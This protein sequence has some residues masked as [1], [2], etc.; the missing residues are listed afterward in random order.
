[1]SRHSSPVSDQRS[2]RPVRGLLAALLLLLPLPAPAI[3]IRHDRSDSDYVVDAARYPQLF[4]LHTRESS[5]KVCMAT[6][7]A[8]RWAITAAHC[9]EQTPIATT[10]AEGRSYS[11][12]IAGTSYLIDTLVVHP[13]YRSAKGRLLG[14]DLALIRL[15]RAVPEVEP[16][17]LNREATELGKVVQLF[18]WGHT[19]NGSTG[20]QRND[21]HFR[22]AENR[23]TD[24][25]R[26]LQFR[27]DDPREKGGATLALE[28]VPA[29][30]DSGGPALL[31]TPNGMVLLGV[32]LGELDLSTAQEP[33]GA[34]QGLYGAT[35]IYER[36]ALHTDWI[37][38]VLGAELPPALAAGMQP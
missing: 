30:G 25:M 19:G 24:A 3:V 14:V 29:L 37:T 6:L 2:W 26:W 15:D 21:G 28:G 11:L 35:E 34:R 27:F 8:P 5:T 10:L 1:M 7:I 33:Q 38:S 12:D 18:G 20:R 16:A 36:I 4:H 17:L 23:I 31:E 9:T 22:R 13:E 32:A